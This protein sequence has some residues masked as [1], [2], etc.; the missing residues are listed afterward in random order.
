MSVYYSEPQTSDED[1]LTIDGY[2]FSNESTQ[3]ITPRIK[4]SL[5]CHE[6]SPTLPFTVD[7][8]PPTDW[9]AVN[10]THSFPSI[11]IP[12]FVV[13]TPPFPD[14]TPDTIPIHIH[15][16]MGFGSGEHATTQGCLT[17]LAALKSLH[18]RTILDMGCGSG[19]L[20]IAATKLF[21]RPVIAVDLDPLSIQATQQNTRMNGCDTTV[22]V[23]LGDGYNVLKKSETFDIITCNIFAGPVCAMAP[24]LTH[25]LTSSGYAIISGLLDRQAS[26]VINAHRAHGLVHKDTYAIEGWSTL[27]FCKE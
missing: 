21:H 4:H 2:M 27:V 22:K 16:M 25:H 8:V 20:S 7:V 24:A 13:S 10:A 9:L 18:P 15:S 1:H 14:S 17:A 3:T 19:I 6:L 11:T 5:E 23:R 12:P 26:D